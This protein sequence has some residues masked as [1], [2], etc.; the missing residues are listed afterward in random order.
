MDI[1]GGVINGTGGTVDT[2]ATLNPSATSAFFH[3]RFT[4]DQQ[5]TGDLFTIWERHQLGLSETSIYT[6]NDGIP[7][8]LKWEIGVNP[9]TFNSLGDDNND[10]IDNL[11]ELLLGYNPDGPPITYQWP[12]P[13]TPSSLV[14]TNPSLMFPTQTR[15]PVDDDDSDNDGWSDSD[16]PNPSV[17]VDFFGTSDAEFEAWRDFIH[18]TISGRTYIYRISGQVNYQDTSSGHFKDYA[19][20]LDQGPKRDDGLYWQSPVTYI[21]LNNGHPDPD[22]TYFVFQTGDGEIQQVR[23]NDIKSGDIWSPGGGGPD[24][25]ADSYEDNSGS[26]GVQAFRPTVDIVQ[27]VPYNDGGWPDPNH[28]MPGNWQSYSDGTPVSTGDDIEVELDLGDDALNNVVVST[29]WQLTVDDGPGEG[30]ASG[31]GVSNDPERGDF[32]NLPGS[33]GGRVKI[34]GTAHLQNGQ[35]I[36][37]DGYFEIGVRTKNVTIIHWI[38]GDLISPMAS[39]NDSVI[40]GLI[41][42]NFINP[43]ATV[44]NGLIS[45]YGSIGDLKLALAQYLLKE[46]PDAQ[47]DGGQSFATPNA[48]LNFLN[49]GSSKYRLGNTLRLN[50]SPFED[51]GAWTFADSN[52]QSGPALV[53]SGHTQLPGIPNGASVVTLVQHDWLA[54]GLLQPDTS[55]A[56]FGA[57]RQ[58]T[59]SGNERL[60]VSAAARVGNL[61]QFTAWALGQPVPWIYSNITYDVTSTDGNTIQSPD[62]SSFPSCTIFIDSSTPTTIDQSSVAAF[63]ATA[64][65]PLPPIDP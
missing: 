5:L 7:D 52:L 36:S 3:A 39:F 35:T 13:G 49:S 40:N 24:G 61:G 2:T 14:T 11:S 48:V 42:T 4:G 63:L 41:Q 56:N 17:S 16:T 25:V 30:S 45:L 53:T 26:L 10:G 51:N 57:E 21:D 23:P 6:I 20:I 38:N 33:V 58:D 8:Y 31:S 55:S 15:P 22:N 44:R 1:F 27:Y 19:Y 59:N 43:P 9:A 46:A 50:Y 47:P 18:E 60:R 32:I 34:V 64:N 37:A 62:L 29:T 28:T 12:P 65:N 54:Y